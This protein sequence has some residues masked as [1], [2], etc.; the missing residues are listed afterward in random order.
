MAKSPSKPD[1]NFD[2]RRIRLY[3]GRIEKGGPTV[4]VAEM[5][6]GK[7]AAANAW[8]RWVCANVPFLER[9]GKTCDP[10][11]YCGHGMQGHYSRIGPCS[12]IVTG[13]DGKSLR[14]AC[15]GPLLYSRGVPHGYDTAERVEAL[16]RFRAA[17]EEIGDEPRRLGWVE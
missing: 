4:T 17:L 6:A 16:K 3:L 11:A 9:K 8:A 14:C 12:E 13:G 10:C 15:S 5:I 2:K 1:W 7:T